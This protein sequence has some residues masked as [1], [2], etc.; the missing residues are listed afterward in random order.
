[1]A[2]E[3]IFKEEL[4]PEVKL[5]KVQAPL[6]ARKAKSGQFVI[7]RASEDGERIP[8]TLIDWDPKEGTITLV[9]KEVGGS[10]K[11]LGKLEVGGAIRDLVGPL[12]KPSE[13][14]FHSKVCVIGRGVAI[15]AAYER[16]KKMKEAG[17]NVTA[18]IS[19]RTAKQLI[20]KDQLKGVCD[21]LYIVTDDGSEGMKGYAND[22]LR[23]LL[24]SGERFDLVY[25][26]GAAT[27]MRSI[28]ETTKLYKIKTIVSLNS[29]MVDGTGMCGCCRVTVGGKPMFACVDGPD[30]DAHL[31]DFEEFR[32][33]IHMYDEEEKVA[34]KILGECGCRS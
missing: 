6:I 20:F 26:V 19:A 31:V 5:I 23:S 11:E 15:A 21:K 18:I 12:G 17:N 7:L 8:L 27:L 29:L 32:A 28:S 24:D 13:I 25:A 2:N 34:L 14:N 1:M 10:T 16:A 33:R 22:L 9:F 30:F 3:I 4:A